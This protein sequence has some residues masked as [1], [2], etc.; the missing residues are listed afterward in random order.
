MYVVLYS[1]NDW[2]WKVA[3]FG[4]STEL[5]LRSSLLS[6]NRRGTDAYL[7]PEFFEEPE[8]GGFKYTKQLDIWQM[9]CIIYE[10]AVGTQAFRS[11]WETRNF[12]EGRFKLQIPLENDP[13]FGEQC[14]TD[15]SGCILSMLQVEESVR[16]TAAEMVAK[17]ETFRQGLQASAPTSSPTNILHSFSPSTLPIQADTSVQQEHI[18]I[19]ISNLYKT[20]L[21]DLK[22][23]M[24]TQVE[25]KRKAATEAWMK[26]RSKLDKSIMELVQ[27]QMAGYQIWLDKDT[28]EFT[29]YKRNARVDSASDELLTQYRTTS[30]ARNLAKE[31]WKDQDPLRDEQIRC[32]AEAEA[33]DARFKEDIEEITVRS[34]EAVQ[35]Q[36]LEK[37]MLEVDGQP[38]VPSLCP[39]VFL[40]SA[41]E[42]FDGTRIHGLGTGGGSR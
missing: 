6:D 9:G 5:Q 19:T 40:I 16:P 29:K 27:R 26:E 7:P 30:T 33:C 34:F 22:Q 35:S 41:T 2:V 14:K 31:Y 21:L 12:K 1:R 20:R 39:S 28:R 11:S 13:F 23:S 4:I 38:Q 25:A 18:V 17:F 10:L 3:D 24:V 42:C 37:L 36:E 32:A 15:I 8:S